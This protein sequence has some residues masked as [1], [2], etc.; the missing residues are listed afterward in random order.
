M[1]VRFTLGEGVTL[2]QSLTWYERKPDDPVFRPLR[3]FTLDPTVSAR[4]GAQATAH[5]PYEPL[6]E[7]G[8]RGCLFEVE[9]P[10]V[11]IELD[12]PAVL[13]RNGL[14]PSITHPQF[15]Q[16]MVYGV[17]NGVYSVFR[18]ALGRHLAWAFPGRLKLK[19]HVA[20]LANAFYDKASRSISFGYYAV[21]E[22][23]TGNVPPGS[24]LY[25][26]LSHDVIVHEVTHALLD[27]LRS[28]F[29]IPSNPDV[30]AFHEALADLIAIFQH[31]TY[32]DALETQVR[33][34]RGA[35]RDS[36]LLFGIAQELGYARGTQTPLRVFTSDAPVYNAASGDPHERAGVLVSAVFDA[37]A[38]LFSRKTERYVRLATGG[39]GVLAPGQL[40]HDLIAIFTDAAASLASQFLSICIR[41]IDYCPPVDLTFGEYLRAMVTADR[42]LVPED[43]WGYREALIHAF[44]CRRI[45]PSDVKNLSEEA[46]LWEPPRRALPPVAGLR[47]GELR[48]AGDPASPADAA[49]LER[50]AAVL[51]QFVTSAEHRDVFGLLAD[52][53][54]IDPPCVQSIRTSRRAGPS[55]EVLFDLIAEVTQRRTV[56]HPEKRTRCEFYGGVTVILDPQARVRYTVLKRTGHEQRLARQLGTFNE[57]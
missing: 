42:D 12:S 41:A 13:I 39:S 22:T 44:A 32:R 57:S 43:P 11:G 18:R 55:G 25:T 54:G 14:P 17:A 29:L 49:E 53:A 19:P 50:Q 26:C 45:Y 56:I 23:S 15:H 2:A 10:Y 47:F 48:F 40:P 1:A 38:T 30:P 7:P 51:G 35:I 16:Q 34:Y 5:V 9:S 52:G 4:D 24:L 36:Q 21:P 37:F 3:I 8:P 33:K 6:P 28:Q 31:F 20:N 27:G 46:L